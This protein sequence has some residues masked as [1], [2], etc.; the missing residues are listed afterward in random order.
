VGRRTLKDIE[1]FR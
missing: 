1:K